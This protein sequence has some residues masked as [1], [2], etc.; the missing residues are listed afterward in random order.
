MEKKYLHFQP[1][2][3]GKFKCDGAKCN[4]RCCKNWEISIDE[5]SYKKYPPEV[6]EH[7]KFNSESKTYVMELDEKRSCPMLTENN[8]CR[9]SMA[10][11]TWRRFFVRDLRDL[12]A[13]HV[14]LWQLF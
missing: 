10:T 9:C 8:L 4:A 5:D 3:V 12:S 6:A 7:I 1:E 14:Q 13:S 2:Y 11:R